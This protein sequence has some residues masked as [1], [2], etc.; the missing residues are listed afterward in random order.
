MAG[1]SKWANRQHRKGRQDAVRGKA[2]SRCSREIIVAARS[3][4]GNPEINNRLR[5]AIQEA[6]GVNMPADT[7]ERAIKRGT[8][9]LEGTSYEEVTYEGYGPGGVALMIRALS[10]NRQRTVADVRSI[11]N[12]RGGRMAEAG[13]VAYLFEPKG[14]IFVDRSA[15]EED[16][17]ME[18]VLD[19]GAEDVLADE[20]QF[21]VRTA[22]S[23]FQAVRDAVEAAGIETSSAELT[24]V[25]ATTMPVRDDQARSLLKLLEELD[26]QEDVQQVYAN[27]EVDDALLAEATKN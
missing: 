14:V 13:G 3:G 24:M 21:E 5:L 26:D 15:A 16:T 12:K 7:I 8:G 1:H 4:G 10:D 20:E 6:R 18:A 25:P 27:F 17:L 9:E 23:D 19:A 22:P 11:L 2:F